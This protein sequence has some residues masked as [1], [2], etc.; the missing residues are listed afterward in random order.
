[1]LDNSARLLL[2]LKAV[3][4]DGNGTASGESEGAAITIRELVN[5]KK[6]IR[7]AIAKGNNTNLI[8]S[9]IKLIELI[10]SDNVKRY[11]GLNSLLLKLD[12]NCNNG[13]TPLYL[14]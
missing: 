9:H 5:G 11:E 12:E 13:P 14:L 8:E 6:V 1:M 4:A 2:D 10:K 7:I 3:S